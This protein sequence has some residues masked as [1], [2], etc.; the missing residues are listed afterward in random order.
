MESGVLVRCHNC[1][2]GLLFDEKK[3]LVLITHSV[4][5]SKDSYSE[6]DE[7]EISCPYCD[8][9]EQSIPAK[10]FHPTKRWRRTEIQTEVRSR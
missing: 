7:V 10:Y 6:T 5:I 9:E 4:T 8:C 1:G 3:E 2:S